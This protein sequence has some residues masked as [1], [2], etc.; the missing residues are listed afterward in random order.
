MTSAPLPLSVAPITLSPAVFSTGIGSPVSID[1][2]TLRSAL[3]HLAID[4]HLLAGSDPQAIADVHMRQ[5]NVLF[6]AVCAEATRRLGRESKQRPER[7]RGTRARLQFQD[8][9]KQ[10]QRDDYRGRLEIHADAAVLPEGVRE[11]TGRH[12]RDDA[13]N[14][15]GADAGADQRPHVGAAVGDRLR[16]AHEERPAR[17]QHHRRGDHQLEPGP[18][19]RAAAAL[20]RCPNI[21]SASTASDSGRVHQKRRRKSVS[22]GFSPS[23]RLGIIGSSAMP[24]IGQLPG[25]SRTICGCIGQVYCEPAGACSTWA[26]VGFRYRSGSERNLVRQPAEQNPYSVPAWTA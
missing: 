16:P 20:A 22:S 6:R 26:S 10:R 24:Q 9:A 8:L 13:V 19:S 11:Q 21:A 14:E 1:S 3:Q 12:G 23:S 17:P 2:S 5:R 18:R 4:R 25:A 7:S 15:C